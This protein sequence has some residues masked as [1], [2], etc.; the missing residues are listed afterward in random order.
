[1]KDRETIALTP[2]RKHTAKKCPF[3]GLQ[4]GSL[5]ALPD[6]ACRG[7]FLQLSSSPFPSS[8]VRKEGNRGEIPIHFSFLFICDVKALWKKSGAH[9][10]NGP[11]L[12]LSAKYKQNRKKYRGVRGGESLLLRANACISDTGVDARKEGAGQSKE[13][14]GWMDAFS[15]FS[16]LCSLS[17]V[18]CCLHFRFPFI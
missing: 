7:Q 1:M 9:T 10:E 12:L 4:L 15:L 8:P 17:G 3:G 16:V 11:P 2:H 13:W 18:P 5:A 14:I 6:V